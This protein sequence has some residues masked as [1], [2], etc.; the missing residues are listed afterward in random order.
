MTSQ[1]ILRACFS[2]IIATVMLLTAMPIQ[3]ALA[4]T[5]SILLGGMDLNSYCAS[6]SQGGAILNGAIWACSG[7]NTTIDLNAA[8][9][10]QYKV[11]GA[12]AVQTLA[13]NPYSYQCYADAQPPTP[14]TNLGGMDLDQ[15]CVSVGQGPYSFLNGQIWSCTGNGQAIDL[16]AACVWQYNIAGAYAAEAVTGNVYTYNCYAQAQAPPTPNTATDDWATYKYD[17]SR[18]SY[19]NLETVINPNTASKLHQVLNVTPSSATAVISDS[20]AVVNNVM[21]YGDWTGAFYARSTN[22]TILW[23][24]NLGVMTP[25]AANGC[26]PASLGVVSSPSVKTITVNG[27]PTS[28]VYIAGADGFMY[29]L[30]ASNGSVLWKTQLTDPATG[31]L[32]WDSPTE[33]NGS[34]FIGLASYGDCPLVQG[35]LFKLNW[36]TGVVQDVAK[37]VPDGCVGAGEWASPTIDRTNNKIYISTG[38]QDNSCKVN[39]QLYA[40]PNALAMVELDMNLNILGA[41]RIP[42]AEQGVDSDF[43]ISPTLSTV[44]INGVVTQLVS[45][46]NKNG[47]FYIFK[48]DAISAGPIVDEVLGAGGSCPDCGQGT[49]S[50]SA[51]DGKVLYQGTGSTKVNGINYKASVVALN[52]ANGALVWQHGL[53]HALVASPSLIKGVLIVPEGNHI[54]LINTSNGSEILQL[55][56]PGANSVFD[57]PAAIA[58]GMIFVGDLNGDFYEFS[59]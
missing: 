15:Y 18:S 59:L 39:G 25:P 54:D 55:T 42:A 20:P 51:T 21:Y 40:E 48:R 26:S 57:A 45:G 8:C 24:R 4:V 23:T 33:Y 37:L 10:W 12:S 14:P 50:S 17:S 1:K 32:L 11:P 58:R 16:N 35:K 41:W 31:G 49:I 46:G 29:A 36:R 7:N 28:I 13:N 56:P 43:G 19:N 9:V 6:Q 27:T 2:F 53:A 3:D 22:G 30:Y 38:T 52:P 5:G 47:R 34:V 44:T